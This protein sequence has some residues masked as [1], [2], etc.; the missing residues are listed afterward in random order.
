[1]AEVTEFEDE[2]GQSPFGLWFWRL[3]AR[4]ASKVTRTLQKLGRGLRPDV[5]PVGEGVFETKIHFGP[6]YR[7]YFGL[8]GSEVIILL[9]GGDK[10]FQAQDIVKAKQRWAEYRAQ[11]RRSI[12]H[13]ANPQI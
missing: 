6:G 5:E 1:M 7:V 12:R 3:D 9:G 13:V 4:A 11:R 10:S 2:S 8:E